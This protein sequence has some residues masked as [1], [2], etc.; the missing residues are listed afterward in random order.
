MMVLWNGILLWSI[1][2][3]ILL[4]CFNNE[5]SKILFWVKLYN[6][7]VIYVFLLKLKILLNGVLFFIVVSICWI[8][9]NKMLRV[10]WF[11]NL[12]VLVFFGNYEYYG[13]GISFFM[14]V[15]GLL[16]DIGLLI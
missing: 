4:V 9:F 14:F 16:I 12:F 6:K 1:V 13:L 10:I 5:D 8:V 2:G 7:D 15:C 11:F 3:R